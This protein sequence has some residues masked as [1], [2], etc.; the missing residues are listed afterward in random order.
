MDGKLCD[1]GCCAAGC[2]LLVRLF[3]CLAL[4]SA[5]VND[6]TKGAHSA[7]IRTV[8]VA[9]ISDHMPH[10]DADQSSLWLQ[11]FAPL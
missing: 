4:H 9:K 3:V 2:L 1:V 11:F 5:R 6:F 7:N 8:S 10:L